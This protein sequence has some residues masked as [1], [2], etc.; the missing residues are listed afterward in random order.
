MIVTNVMMIEVI[1]L[2]VCYGGV[3]GG[4]RLNVHGKECAAKSTAGPKGRAAEGGQGKP[5]EAVGF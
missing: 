4:V 1:V 5:H 3:P 2:A